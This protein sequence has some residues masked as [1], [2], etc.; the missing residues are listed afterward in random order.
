MKFV[1][2][3]CCLGLIFLWMAYIDHRTGFVYRFQSYLAIAA[4]SMI[5]F[6][7]AEPAM[8]I[9]LFF[10]LPEIFW[11]VKKDYIGR[12]DGYVYSAMALSIS[13]ITDSGSYLLYLFVHQLLA[14]LIFSLKLHRQK[15]LPAFRSGADYA[16]IPSLFYSW[17]SVIVSSSFVSFS[18]R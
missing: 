17:V 2:E 4:G 12:G 10:Y 16:F 11:L 1:L 9:Q 15:K 6:R 8:Y 5:Y 3:F 14:N 18:G 13:G 7:S